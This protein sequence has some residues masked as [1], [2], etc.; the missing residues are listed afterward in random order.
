[1]ADF[2]TDCIFV[3]AN[4]NAIKCQLEAINAFTLNIK[5]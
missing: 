3:N 4:F 5:V 2:S 1:V